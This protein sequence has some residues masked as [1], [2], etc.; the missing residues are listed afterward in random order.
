MRVA[1]Y[2][3][4]ELKNR[5]SVWEQRHFD[6][7]WSG[8]PVRQGRER[9]PSVVARSIWMTLYKEWHESNSIKYA[10]MKATVLR[11]VLALE[12]YAIFTNISTIVGRKQS[13][14]EYLEIACSESELTCHYFEQAISKTKPCENNW[15]KS[16]VKKD[17]V[18]RFIISC[19]FHNIFNFLM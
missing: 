17:K 4:N 15:H 12:F 10:T 1:N 5:A 14:R 7:P 8:G 19:N 18:Q 16:T 13:F 9:Q 11:Y 2:S 6:A 3:E